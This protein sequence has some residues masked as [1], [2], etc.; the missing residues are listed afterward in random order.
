MQRSGSSVGYP[1]YSGLPVTRNKFFKKMFFVYILMREVDES[2]YIGQTKDLMKRLEYH[3]LGRSKYT[4]RKK[5]WKVVY[6]EKYDTRKEAIARERFLKK[7]R[8]RDFYYSLIHNWSGS[9][10]G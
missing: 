6:F 8:N 1:E 5:P 4:N 2:F 9:S 10:V 7:Q 3:N